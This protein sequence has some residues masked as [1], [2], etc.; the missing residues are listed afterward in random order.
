MVGTWGIRKLT[1]EQTV[2]A[3]LV[4]V[5]REAEPEFWFV[6]VK[7]WLYQDN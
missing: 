6:G 7:P 3:W 5:W 1:T 4:D 2:E